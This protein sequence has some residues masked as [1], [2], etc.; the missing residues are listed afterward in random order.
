MCLL[1]SA[2]RAR[3][4]DTRQTISWYTGLDTTGFPLRTSISVLSLSLARGRGELQDCGRHATL[5]LEYC[6]AVALRRRVRHDELASG[7]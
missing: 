5:P 4:A 2:W 3:S 6:S 7:E 1:G